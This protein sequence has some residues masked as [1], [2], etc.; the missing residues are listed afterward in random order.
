MPI[1]PPFYTIELATAITFFPAF[2]SFSGSQKYKLKP[3]A[4]DFSPALLVTPTFP[5]R[6]WDYTQPHAASAA[7]IERPRRGHPL[8]RGLRNVLEAIAPHSGPVFHVSEPFST[9]PRSPATDYRVSIYRVS[10]YRVSV[11]RVASFNRPRRF[12]KQ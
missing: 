11:Y 2:S 6:F 5:K 10:V 1:Y 8:A 9:R 4:R 7:S 3:K 12:G